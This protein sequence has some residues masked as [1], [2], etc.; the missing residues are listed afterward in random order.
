VKTLSEKKLS[1]EIESV[2]S[3]KNMDYNEL[4]DLSKEM[5]IEKLSVYH[6]ELLFQNDE[7]QR[8]NMETETTKQLY[9]DLF[10]QTPVP[11]LLISTNNQIIRLNES[12]KQLLKTNQELRLVTDYIAPSSQDDYYFFTRK[13]IQEKAKQTVQ[14]DLLIG[15]KTYHV[16]MHANYLESSSNH[17]M[18][19]LVVLDQTQ[20]KEYQDQIDFLVEHDQLTNIYNRRYYEQ[21][22]KHLTKQSFHKVGVVYID[23]NNLK[24][25]N[26]AFGHEQGDKVLIQLCKNVQDRLEEKD[27][28]CR[29]GG[30]EFVLFIKRSSNR[31]ITQ[32]MNDIRLI[33]KSMHINDLEV[34]AS[35]GT[36]IRTNEYMSIDNVIKVAEEN[37]YQ[38]KIYA[39]R[40]G[41]LKIVGSILSALHGKHPIEELHSDR[42]AQL[43]YMFASRMG[44]DESDQTRLRSAGL[45][46]DIGKIAL[47]YSIIEAKRTLTKEEY[48]EI[49]RHPEI[50]YKILLS[51]RTEALISETVL[52]HH[53]HVDG[54]G[55]PRGLVSNQITEPAKMLTICDSF[56]AM[57]SE[58]PYKKPRT[59]EDAMKEL[60]RCSGTQFDAELT[61]VFIEQVIPDINQIY[62]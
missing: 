43:M 47:N 62:Q 54:S 56:D 1:K 11:I 57:I 17:P 19:R 25:V 59:I 7:L 4:L 27:V 35:V 33:T 60:Q 21:H 44:Y 30:D 58:R 10:D 45:L 46:H 14:L 41:K 38:E 34:S 50:G 31:K 49:K 61:K 39:S 28:F 29:I 37:M 6:E 13:I 16:M 36:A 22:I 26:D 5:I 42:V 15:S 2:L 12:A 18:I 32:V 9:Q 40:Q 51:S 20:Q 55:Y 53:E 24:L 3:Q 52:M 8:S 23:L 48:E